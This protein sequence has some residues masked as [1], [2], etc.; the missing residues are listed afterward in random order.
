MS[1]WLGE[2]LTGWMADGWMVG[3]MVGCLICLLARIGH[4][5]NPFPFTRLKLSSEDTHECQA[6][7]VITGRTNGVSIN[8]Q[9]QHPFKGN[10]AEMLNIY[11]NLVM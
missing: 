1:G 6:K 9:S 2:W 4:M 10:H 11:Q 3:W 8:R 7:R 5:A